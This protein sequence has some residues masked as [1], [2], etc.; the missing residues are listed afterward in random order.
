M[1]NSACRKWDLK[2][3]VEEILQHHKEIEE[4]YLFG[5]RAYNTG[6]FRSDIDLLAFSGGIP[7]PQAE[8][9]AWIHDEFPPVDLFWTYDKIIAQSAANGSSIKFRKDNQAGCKD[10]VEQVEAILL[11]DSKNGF[12][13]GD[14]WIQEALSDCEYPM[15]VIPDY[16]VMDAGTA[17]T[18]ALAALERSGIKTYFAGSTWEEIGHSIV[19]IIKTSLIKPIKYQ[20]NAKSFSFDT[21]H[22]RQEYDFQNLI[23]LLLRPIF[24]DIESENVAIQIDGNKKIADFGLAA[25]KLIIEAKHIDTTSKKAEVIKT[26][27]GLK[28]F[29]SENPNVECLVFLVLYEKTV[30]LDPV[31][32]QAR[33]SKEYSSPLICVEFLENPYSNI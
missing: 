23:H 6:S 13:E 1:K 24:S 30:D 28:S 21:I 32:L 20:K 27:D 5:S 16:S 15:S 9:N 7:M 26:L 33:F 31:A 3:I 22:L 29:Y 4:I 18:D 14:Y 25:N 11:W 12:T 17:I 10:V 2:I 19:D 8:I